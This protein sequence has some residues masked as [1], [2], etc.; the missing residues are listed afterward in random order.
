MGAKGERDGKGSGGIGGCGREGI[1][2]AQCHTREDCRG[3]AT[4]WGRLEGQAY[5]CD[6]EDRGEQGGYMNHNGM[7]KPSKSTS[8]TEELAETHT[9][10]P[11]R[12]SFCLSYAHAQIMSSNTAERLRVYGY[13]MKHPLSHPP[14][15]LLTS[16]RVQWRRKRKVG[17]VCR[18]NEAKKRCMTSLCFL[19]QQ[20]VSLSSK[21]RLHSLLTYSH[22]MRRCRCHLVRVRSIVKCGFLRTLKSRMEARESHLLHVTAITFDHFL[23]CNPIE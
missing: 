12:L 10:P 1:W 19:L 17:H 22:R 3:N 21:D 9:I 11:P 6:C 18:F 4:G 15:N 23:E 8:Y 5:Q 14:T 13:L 20:S 16:M 2:A 7:E